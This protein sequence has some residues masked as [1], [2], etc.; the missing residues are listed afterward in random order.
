MKQKMK[1]LA[2]TVVAVMCVVGVFLGQYMWLEYTKSLKEPTAKI[3][4]Y[5][6]Q[7]GGQK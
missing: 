2:V 5:E 3:S 1:N 7:R 4:V 6:K